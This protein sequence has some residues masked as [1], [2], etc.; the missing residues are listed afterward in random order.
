MKDPLKVHYSCQEKKVTSPW[1]WGPAPDWFCRDRSQGSY[2][3]QGLREVF[4][5]P[6]HDLSTCSGIFV[7]TVLGL[8][9]SFCGTHKWTKSSCMQVLQPAEPYSWPHSR[10]FY[11]TLLYCIQVFGG[12]FG[13][14]APGWI[15][16]V[17]LCGGMLLTLADE[18]TL[19]LLP[20]DCFVQLRLG[21]SVSILLGMKVSGLFCITLDSVETTCRGKVNGKT[22]FKCQENIFSVS[23]TKIRRSINWMIQREEKVTV[24]YG[25]PGLCFEL[26]W[27]PAPWPVFIM[28]VFPSKMLITKMICKWVVHCP[29]FAGLGRLYSN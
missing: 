29:L 7:V 14:T 5:C 28:I 18:L 2:E 10:N 27:D 11:I 26:P 23:S 15:I 25:N 9:G 24:P 17:H 13:E 12:D 19:A 8:H 20:E 16:G 6:R 22:S 21:L 4:I 3:G 1:I